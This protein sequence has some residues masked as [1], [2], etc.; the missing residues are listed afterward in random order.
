MILVA[1]LLV[2]GA[3]LL[4]EARNKQAEIV[5]TSPTIST[6]TGL[7]DL[8]ND[9]DWKKILLANEQASSTNTKD[10]TKD[11]EELTGTDLL[12]RDFF[13]KYME[14]RQMGGANDK[15]S[16]EDLVSQVLKNGVML[17]SPK[18]YT[19]ADILIKDDSSKEAI[20]KYASD[21]E[22]VFKLY[23]ISSRN[24]AVIAKD[25]VD[26]ETPEILKEIDPII[27]SYKNILSGLIKIQAP[28]TITK[29]HLDLVNSVSSLVFI[30]E[31]LRKIGVDPLAGV[32][33]IARYLATIQQFS[34]AFNNVKNLNQN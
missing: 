5:Y 11:Q 6:P 25:A 16:Q 34:T 26:R 17:A 27:K 4:A 7:A 18:T 30:A 20:K 33:A 24:E 21:V 28:Q 15:L 19:I 29:M 8:G 10:L 32:Q 12:G 3:F 31:N 2:G 14:L 22:M 13:A 9:V 1:V 23:T